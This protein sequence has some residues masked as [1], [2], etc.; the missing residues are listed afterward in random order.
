M[1]CARRWMGIVVRCDY[2]LDPAVDEAI[3]FVNDDMMLVSKRL[4]KRH[5]DYSIDT[6]LPLDVA[7]EDEFIQ[8]WIHS[9]ANVYRFSKAV[10]LMRP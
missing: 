4:C 5:H 7:D 3:N 10:K 8:D 6:S 2:C 1:R 9:R